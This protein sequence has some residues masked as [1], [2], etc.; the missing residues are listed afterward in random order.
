LAPAHAAA[1]TRA[2]RVNVSARRM[3]GP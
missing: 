2:D 1:S 3:S